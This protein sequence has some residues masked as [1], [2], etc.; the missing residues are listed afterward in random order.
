MLES[1]IESAD[2]PVARL[3]RRA[4]VWCSP[5]TRVAD[6]LRTLREQRIGSMI[7]VGADA[8]PVGILT[9]RD[10]IDR[11]ALEPASLNAPIASVMTPH[12]LTT[13]PETSAYQAD[14]DDPLRRESY[15]AGQ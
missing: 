9:L 10:V 11:I 13:T 4:P 14:D 15:R 12:P 3:I 8:L 1:A 5:D 2:P 7:V 6:V